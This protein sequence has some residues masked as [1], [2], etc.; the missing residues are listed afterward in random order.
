MLLPLLM[1][2]S[3]CCTRK[4]GAYVD[5]E[6]IVEIFNRGV[7]DR[8]SLG[9]ALIRDQ[10]IQP[11]ADD[12]ANLFSELVRAVRSGEI[13]GGSIG[14]AAEDAPVSGISALIGRLLDKPNY[15]KN[16]W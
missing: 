4:N 11:I 8:R 2:G 6:E 5:G 16:R 13:G 15:K 1:I 9:H 12:I 7:L 14:A 10:D 3:C